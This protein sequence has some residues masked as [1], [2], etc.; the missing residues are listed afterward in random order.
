M[1]MLLKTVQNL[2]RIYGNVANKHIIIKKK[3]KRSWA[4]EKRKNM[5]VNYK[6]SKFVQ[7]IG[8]IEGGRR[9]GK[10]GFFYCG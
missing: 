1:S 4:G 6:G 3:Y 5:V 7:N 9:K 10:I 8:F 2:L